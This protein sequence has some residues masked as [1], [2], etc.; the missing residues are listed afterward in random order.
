MGHLTPA[1][2][3]LPSI[4]FN[5]YHTTS[6]N[7]CVMPTDKD[8]IDVADKV[9]LQTSKA[10]DILKSPQLLRLL[11]PRQVLLSKRLYFFVIQV[12]VSPFKSFQI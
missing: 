5:G 12:V 3:L 9:G 1:F 11:Q 6:I 8:I 2:D 7:D 10:K 4:G